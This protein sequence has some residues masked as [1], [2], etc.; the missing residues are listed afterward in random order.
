MPAKTSQKLRTIGFDADDTLWHNERFFQMTQSRFAELLADFTDAE[1]L[2]ARLLEA[3]KRNIGHYGF[4][5]KG[6]MLSMIETALEVTEH[7]VPGEVISQI[8]AAG[9]DMLSHPIELLPHARAAVEEL[10]GRHHI[11][12]ITKGDLLDQERKLA[13]SGLG[14]LFDAVEI[15]SHKTPHTYARIFGG[16]APGEAMMVGNSMKSDVLPALEVGAWG[17]F[18]PQELGWALEHAEP[19]QAQSRFREIADLGKLPALV[20]EIGQSI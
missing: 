6:F 5:I 4:G 15:V 16:H 8:L 7:R 2:D 3:E 9:Q 14:D 18:V 10:S 13:Q 17:I 1:E 11:A 20:D 19:P 12:L